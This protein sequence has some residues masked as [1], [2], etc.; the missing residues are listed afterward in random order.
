VMID[1]QRTFPT[2]AAIISS[3]IAPEHRFHGG[4]SCHDLGASGRE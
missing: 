3:M 2:H 1:G 4:N